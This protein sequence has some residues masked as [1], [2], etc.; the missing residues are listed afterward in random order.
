MLGKDRSMLGKDRSMLGKDPSRLGKDRSM[1]GKDPS[2]L[3][4]NCSKLGKDP[5]MLRKISLKDRFIIAS[6]GSE[7]FKHMAH[8]THTQC[9]QGKVI[10]VGVRASVYIYL[11]V[12]VTNF[13][14][15]VT[16]G[17]A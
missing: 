11:C 13:F 12:C 4:K 14:F 1:L 9:K 5:S 17:I 3:G 10:S 15:N 16:L 2:R 8:H 6:E 7:F